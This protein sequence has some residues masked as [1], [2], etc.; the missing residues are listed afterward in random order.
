M[1]PSYIDYILAAIAV[2]AIVTGAMR[3][4]VRQVGS[5][6]GLVG[7]VIVCRLF[8]TDIA[9]FLARDGSDLVKALIYVLVFLLV[10]TG[11]CL[12]AHLVGSVLSAIK[13]RAFDRIGGAVFRC[14]LWMF[15][16]SLAINLYIRIIPDDRAL[17][18]SGK[19]PWRSAVVSLAPE[20]LGFIINRDTVPLV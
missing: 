15:F 9:N 4:L 14:L 19:Q 3:G 10:Y 16:V 7:G 20:V 17:F 12:I 6:A 13:L 1:T 2:I 5:I 11:F 18:N 8:G